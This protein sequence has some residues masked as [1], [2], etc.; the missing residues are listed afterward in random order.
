MF[1]LSILTLIL[2]TDAEVSKVVCLNVDGK[3]F[4]MNFIDEPF[5]DIATVQFTF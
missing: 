2:F 5:T 4:Q 1:T 3:E